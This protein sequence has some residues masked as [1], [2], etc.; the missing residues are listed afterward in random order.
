[1]KTVQGHEVCVWD[2]ERGEVQLW[3]RWSPGEC[4]R[5]VR[6]GPVHH[7]LNLLCFLFFQR[8]GFSQRHRC[9]WSRPSEV[10]TLLVGSRV[11]TLLPTK[12]GE[13]VAGWRG[14][15]ASSH[16]RNPQG[17]FCEAR[18]TVKATCKGPR[19][20][21]KLSSVTCQEELQL[22]PF[23]DSGPRILSYCEDMRY[24]GAGGSWK[25]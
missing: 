15:I 17:P 20:N 22:G 7:L 1:M 19:I 24:L 3:S 12:S 6:T 11:Q 4:G 13:P 18:Q 2:R 9:H 16:L 25:K 8:A 23:P 21:T 5:L 14:R 10:R